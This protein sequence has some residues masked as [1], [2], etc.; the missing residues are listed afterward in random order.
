MEK[1][2][3]VLAVLA[4]GAWLAWHVPAE[5]RKRV[6]DVASVLITGELPR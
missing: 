5:D 6:H 1:F 4:C 3:A 2:L